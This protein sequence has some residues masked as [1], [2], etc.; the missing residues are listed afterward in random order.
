MKSEPVLRHGSRSAGL[1]AALTLAGLALRVMLL[2]VVEGAGV[3]TLRLVGLAVGVAPVLALLAGVGTGAAWA[4]A[5]EA[6]TGHCDSLSRSSE[7]ALTNCKSRGSPSYF[8]QALL[9]CT[10]L[11]IYRFY[12]SIFFCE[13]VKNV[14]K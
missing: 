13:K 3:P 1:P 6:V 9:A 14:S 7:I 8:R 12:L 4:E 5:E 11:Y 2:A 10:L